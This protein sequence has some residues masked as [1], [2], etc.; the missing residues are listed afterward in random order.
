L[1]AYQKGTYYTG[2]KVFNS[3][4]VPIKYLSQHTKQ[5]KL[6]LKTYY[7]GIKIFNNLPSDPRS[8]M[9]EKARFK[10]A[11][12]RYL[13]THSFYSVDKYLLSKK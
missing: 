13:N 11:L 12:K 7:A 5:L 2:I 8:L 4:P 9:N 1:S 10:I 6:A 3:L